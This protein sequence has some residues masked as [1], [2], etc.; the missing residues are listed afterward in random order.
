MNDD[1][2]RVPARLL[3]EQFSKRSE[4]RKEHTTSHIVNIEPVA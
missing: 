2:M 4:A 1:V 3:K